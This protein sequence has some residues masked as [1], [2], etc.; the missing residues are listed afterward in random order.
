MQVPPTKP[1]AEPVAVPSDPQ[2]A[3]AAR[4][5]YVLEVLKRP[6]GAAPS[7]LVIQ[8]DTHSIALSFG[9]FGSSRGF[10]FPHAFA[11]KAM[12]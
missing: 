5:E 2:A 8:S 9:S 1:V 10:F 4:I 7:I 12:F 11:H 3:E 6:E